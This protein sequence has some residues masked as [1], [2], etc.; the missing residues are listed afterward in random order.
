MRAPA[1]LEGRLVTRFQE[2]VPS[3]T[4]VV[5]S[6]SQEPGVSPYHWVYWVKT[7]SAYGIRCEIKGRIA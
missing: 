4:V 1:Y 7:W 2:M 5:M 6:Y 3:L